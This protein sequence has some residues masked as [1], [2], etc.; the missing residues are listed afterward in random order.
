MA[1]QT[2]ESSPLLT[3]D[4]CVA[5][6]TLSRASLANRLSPHDLDTLRAHFD[7]INHNRA[8]RVVH[9]AGSGKYFCS[10]YDIGALGDGA[11]P[12]SLYFGETVDLL[13][14][15][16]PVTIAVIH[17]GV[18]GGGTDLALACDFRLGTSNANMFMPATRLGLHFYPG[19]LRRYVNRLGLDQAKRL[20]LTA[21][22]ID[23]QRMKQIGFLTDLVSPQELE[24]ALDALTDTLTAMAPLAL[25]GVKSHLNRIANGDFDAASIRANVLLTER[26]QDLQEGAL[27]FKQKRAP[28]FKGS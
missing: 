10:G 12:S 17:G 26:S 24:P 1:P 15:L 14:A 27:A 22:K 19:G 18:Y 9:I 20:F 6:I 23:A 8:V 4:G 2:S 16:R 11:S 21:E 7:D 25:D 3:I 28:V 5:R 13:E